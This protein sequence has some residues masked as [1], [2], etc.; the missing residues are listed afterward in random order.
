MCVWFASAQQS[1]TRLQPH[2]EEL[3][4]LGQRLRI[5]SRPDLWHYTTMVPHKNSTFHTKI[6]RLCLGGEKSEVGKEKG[7]RKRW[8]WSVGGPCQQHQSAWLSG[9]CIGLFMNTRPVC[10]S[11]V[12]VSVYVCVHVQTPAFQLSLPWGITNHMKPYK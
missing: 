6:T 9:I 1:S 8:Y 3:S 5:S 4:P 12:C 10:L 2:S 11:I 7:G